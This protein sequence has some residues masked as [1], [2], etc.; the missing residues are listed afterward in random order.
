[1]IGSRHPVT[2]ITRIAKPHAGLL[3]LGVLLGALAIGAGIGLMATSGYL[4][5]RA[6]EHP[7]ILALGVAIVGVRFFG[8]S[9]GVLRYLERL[10]SHD[11]ALRAL[12]TV[13]VRLFARLEPLVPAGL[14]GLRT[15]DLLGRFV[16]DVDAL[17]SL[18]LRALGPILIALLAGTLAIG[19][20]FV[21]LP[22]AALV[23]AAFLFLAGVVVPLSGVALTRGALRRE[24]PARAALTAELLEALAA[25]P[26]L[27]AYG[28]AGVA[29][30]R[31]DEA[32][33]ALARARRRSA[34][35]AALSE[36]TTTALTMLAA[37]GVLVV[38]IPAVR[39][40]ALPGVEL[41]LLAL[42]AL[43]A[44]EAVRPLPAAAE[45]LVAASAA[46]RRLLDLTDREALVRDPVEPR[47]RLGPGQIALRGV[48]MRYAPDAPDVLR[49]ADLDLPPGA[50][51][52]LIGASGSGKT[53]IADLLVR[54]R[55]PDAGT[56]LLDG[57][58]LREY[59]QADVRR[60]VGLAGQ[61][62]HLFPTS[63]R[64]N[65][66][67]ARPGASDSELIAALRRAHAWTWVSS[68]PDGLGTNV[69]ERGARVSGGERQRLALAR[70]LLADVRLLV[71]DE[72]D[73][74]LDDE[75]AERLIADLVDSSRS[76]GLGLLLITHRAL[77]RSLFDQVAVLRDG[78]IA[79][80]R[81]D[82]TETPTRGHADRRGSPR[83]E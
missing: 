21:A 83:R 68:L 40:G 77:D 27:V 50:I 47:A 70:A 14:P 2:R 79:L 5:S 32:D 38:A 67:I 63:I 7:P 60:V 62:A 8:V 28:A 73:A 10:V 72:P 35:V 54:F 48:G 9:R 15:G 41:A 57:H 25:A 56:I 31:V 11:A 36:A 66:R 52:A 26:E 71:A 37:V 51:I 34:L 17:Q 69:G 53:T 19:V 29:A 64:E 6:A 42:L 59:A 44:F 49:G 43:G 76:A 20:A 82:A 61:D 80:D 1:V 33:R 55:D 3:G 65:L 78:R 58:D 16:T 12:A 74:H 30:A 22:A 24:A 13:R 45:Q 75:T 4:I 18:Y 81:S 46:A 39:S 23:L